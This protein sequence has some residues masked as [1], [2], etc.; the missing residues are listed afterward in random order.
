M[1]AGQSS[2]TNGF[3]SGGLISG[4]DKSTRIDTFSFASNSN[5]TNVGSLSQAR[6]SAAG[7]QV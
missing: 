7:Q 4:G 5:A 6:G 3:A 1:G 2:T